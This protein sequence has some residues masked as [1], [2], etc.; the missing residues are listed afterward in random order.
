MTNETL[1]QKVK[2]LCDECGDSMYTFLT[3][4]RRELCELEFKGIVFHKLTISFEISNNSSPLLVVNIWSSELTKEYKSSD[5]EASRFWTYTG[6]RSNEN[7]FWCLEF[8]K[9][10]LVK[11]HQNKLKSKTLFD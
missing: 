2:R 1:D 6:P 9:G 8:W 7:I 11:N 3:V 5:E 10:D 4:L